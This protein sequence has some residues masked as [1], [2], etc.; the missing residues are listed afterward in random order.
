[1]EGRLPQKKPIVTEQRRVNAPA[2]REPGQHTASA[3]GPSPTLFP[4]SR[5]RVDQQGQEGARQPQ[6]ATG[7]RNRNERNGLE[8]ANECRLD[9]HQGKRRKTTNDLQANTTDQQTKSRPSFGTVP[10]SDR[11]EEVRQN[12]MSISTQTEVSGLHLIRK[13]RERHQPGDG[14]VNYNPLSLKQ[15]QQELGWT[16]AAVQRMMTNV[17][18]RRPFTVYKQKCRDKTICD[19]LA[20]AGGS[21]T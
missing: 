4:T 19:F 14:S 20:D 16:Q 2:D 17:F 15:L 3:D 6:D 9:M 10:S 8:Q 13:L 12:G 21:V 1:M 18:G 7:S 11:Q 5:V